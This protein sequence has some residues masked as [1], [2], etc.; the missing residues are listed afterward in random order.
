MNWPGPAGGCNNAPMQLPQI[1]RRG[2]RAVNVGGVVIGGDAPVS[3]Q[4]MTNTPTADADATL[5]Q[6]RR[7][8]KA[9]TELVRVAVPTKADTG[10]TRPDRR[11]L[12]GAD[13]RGTCTST[14][15]ARWR[16]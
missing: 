9:G 11:W 1:N 7:L 3:V 12:T 10:R 6:V 5:A 15:T 4:S 16:R 2:T 13:H 8:A 14:L